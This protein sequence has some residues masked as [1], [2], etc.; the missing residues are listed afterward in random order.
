MTRYIVLLAYMATIPIANWMI[1]NVGTCIPNGPCLI[2]VGF[3]LSAPSGVLMIGAALLLRDAVHEQF[4]ARLAILAIVIGAAL[5]GLF[6]PSALAIAS[7]TAFLLSELADFCV[8][9]PLRQ[10]RIYSAVVLS[11]IVGAIVDSGVFLFLAFGS[12]DFIAG[13]VIGKMWVT[14]AVIPFIWKIRRQD[15]PA[16]ELEG[17]QS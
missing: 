14:I 15:T 11:G 5:S 10:K 16:R 3:G 1:G 12:L 6:A 13:Q 9:A 4:G 8:Y 7:G 2:P 17:K